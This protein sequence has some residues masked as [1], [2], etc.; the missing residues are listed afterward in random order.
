MIP[1]RTFAATIHL[2]AAGDGRL[3]IADADGADA[4]EFAAGILPGDV[5]VRQNAAGDILLLIG[6]GNDRVTILGGLANPANRIEEVRFDDT[7]VWS[8]TDLIGFSLTGTDA[9]QNLIGSSFDDVVDAGG[10]DD[11]V[12]GADG[13]DQLSG[14]AGS[15]VLA[16]EAGDDKLAGGSG[17]DI[18]DGGVG[19]DTFIYNLGDGQD[20]IT[21][22]DGFDVVLLGPGIAPGSVSVTR[23]GKDLVLRISQ[24]RVTG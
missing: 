3:I 10:G 14:G 16:G 21:D 18:L 5:T 24:T 6:A 13:D 12:A 1:L 23:D 9:S 17:A 15:D 2:F 20:P 22:E 8:A 4:I 19:D 7:T 11:I